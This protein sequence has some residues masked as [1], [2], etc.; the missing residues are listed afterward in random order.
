MSNTPVLSTA[1]NDSKTQ[2][3]PPSGKQTPHQSQ[4]DART[5]ENDAASKGHPRTGQTDGY[6]K[7]D[8]SAH[9]QDKAASSKDDTTRSNAAGRLAEGK[10]QGPKG[11][12]GTPSQRV[13][14]QDAYVA[15][16]DTIEIDDHQAEADTDPSA[17]RDAPSRDGSSKHGSESAKRGKPSSTPTRADGP[18]D[19]K[20]SSGQGSVARKG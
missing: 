17:K 12:A 3:P 13:G 15:N 2:S 20:N 8:S 7:H 14:D 5:K 9:S 16:T 1:K 6:Q 10:S 18:R 19:P 11:A 4:T